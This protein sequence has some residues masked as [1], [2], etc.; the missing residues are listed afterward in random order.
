MYLFC[1]SFYTH[2]S[3]FLHYLINDLGDMCEQHGAQCSVKTTTAVTL[4]MGTGQE[5]CSG[6]AHLLLA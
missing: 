4:L 6:T 2:S 5:V 3:L 1:T